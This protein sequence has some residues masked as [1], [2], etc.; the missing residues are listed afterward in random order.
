MTSK[1]EIV[2]SALITLGA[3]VINSF[4]DD[5]TE[6][7]AANVKWNIALRATLREYPWKFAT[8]RSTSLA[9]TASDPAFNY[10]Y[11]YTLPSDCLRVIKVNEDFDF[12]VEGRNIITDKEDC[13]IQYVYFNEDTA[14]WD[15]SFTELMVAKMAYELAYTLPRS[16]G[17]VDRMY[18]LYQKQ[19]I[20]A[21]DADSS[22]QMGGTLGQF[23]SSLISVREYN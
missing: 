10:K 1:V 23:E 9:R 14:L 11:Q 2:N 12:K 22:E 3:N 7:I 16:G 21:R 8:K 20:E 6:S 5:T 15:A 18:N 19:L 17:M 4:T 13:Y